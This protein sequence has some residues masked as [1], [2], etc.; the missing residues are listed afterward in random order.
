MFYKIFKKVQIRRNIKAIGIKEITG[1]GNQHLSE[2]GSGKVDLS[3]KKLWTVIEAMEKISPGAKADFAAEIANY[4]NVEPVLDPVALVDS[5]SEEEINQILLAIANRYRK[6][7]QSLL[8]TSTE[9]NKLPTA[10]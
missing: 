5:W 3:S 7:K 4:E 10:V 8:S 6:E 2:F 9:K 1:I